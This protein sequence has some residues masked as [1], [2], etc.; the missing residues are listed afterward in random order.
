MKDFAS[1]FMWDWMR[2]LE[3]FG[4]LTPIG[5]LVTTF[6]VLTVIICALLFLNGYRGKR[7]SALHTLLFPFYLLFG[8]IS[9]LVIIALPV[10]VTV[11]LTVLFLSFILMKLLPFI[12]RFGA[13]V[14]KSQIKR[15]R[16]LNND[17]RRAEKLKGDN[18]ER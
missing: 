17:K 10:I 14:R 16:K 5:T 15:I 12:A 7:I 18:N 13:Y 2:M 6:S 1:Q 3:S 8:I 9:P 4:M 11:G